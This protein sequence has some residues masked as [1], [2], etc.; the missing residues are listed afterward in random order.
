VGT[1]A[2]SYQ[3]HIDYTSAWTES[4]KSQDRPLDV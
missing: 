3:L 1:S 4:V 2:Q